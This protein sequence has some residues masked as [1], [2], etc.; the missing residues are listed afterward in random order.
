MKVLEVKQRKEELVMDQERDPAKSK[1]G[2]EKSR[3]GK[4][5]AL[6]MDQDRDPV[7]EG[8]E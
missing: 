2:H 5:G 6:A 1:E 8:R 4:S 7:K 3:L